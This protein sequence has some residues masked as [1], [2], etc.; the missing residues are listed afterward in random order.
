MVRFAFVV[1]FILTLLT[2]GSLTSRAQEASPVPTGAAIATPIASGADITT[3]SLA[4]IRLPAAA[5]P[6]SPA[7]VD[8]WLATLGPGQ[9]LG[10]R[11]RGVPAQHRG[12]RRPQRRVDGAL[13]RPGPDPAR[14]G[15]RGGG[16]QHRRHHPSRRGGHL[17]RQS[18]RPDVPQPRPGDAHGA[19]LRGLLRRSALDVHGRGR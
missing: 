10:F 1:L 18:G 4:E 9:E 7:I 2:S 6:P 19:Q 12:R 14:R 3:E 13:R 16:S 8:V 5:I 11:D 17:R 15:T